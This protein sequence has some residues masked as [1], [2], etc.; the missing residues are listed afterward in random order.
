MLTETWPPLEN[1][2]VL[3]VFQLRNG[4]S[5]DDDG[6]GSLRDWYCAWLWKKCVWWK[7]EPIGCGDNPGVY[8]A[9]GMAGGG[10]AG[11]LM[12]SSYSRKARSSAS[13]SSRFSSWRLRHASFSSWLTKQDMIA[14]MVSTKYNTMTITVKANR[15]FAC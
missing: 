9:P 7:G 1:D 14:S 5:L 2:D 13:F 12:I 4:R 10:K 8:A 15:A 3:G 6:D 11:E